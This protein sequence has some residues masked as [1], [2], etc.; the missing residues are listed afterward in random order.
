MALTP[1]H[2]APL[3]TLGEVVELL[4]PEAFER[5]EWR[6]Q[7]IRAVAEKRL[8]AAY[9][10][11]REEK[12]RA[13]PEYAKAEQE[14]LP[15][16]QFIE[17]V[18]DKY[19]FFSFNLMAEKKTFETSVNIIDPNSEGQIILEFEPSEIYRWLKASAIPEREIPAALRPLDETESTASKLHPKTE[20]SYQSLIAALIALQYG[21]REIVKPYPLADE[22]LADCRRQDLREPVSRNTLGKILGQLDP[23]QKAT[24]D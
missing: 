9:Q 14:Y 22:I 6:K 2:V 5:E 11:I 13:K 12:F 19:D 1:W 17:H 16:D 3:L 23:V 15:L 24:P 7:I 20:N 18:K 10:A 8:S 4:S 21:S